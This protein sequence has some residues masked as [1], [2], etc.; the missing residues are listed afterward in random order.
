M[1]VS[2]AI[3]R[4]PRKSPAVD[5]QS[6]ADRT[7]QREKARIKRVRRAVRNQ[8]ALSAATICA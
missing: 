2:K 6:E 8:K 7:M 3:E 1:R 5:V 4:N